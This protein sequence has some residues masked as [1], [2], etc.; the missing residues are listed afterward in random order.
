MNIIGGGMNIG[1][2]LLQIHWSGGGRKFKGCVSKF[3]GCVSNKDT[4]YN[5]WFSLN[6]NFDASPAVFLR[7]YKVL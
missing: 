6:T 5:T 1:L 2:G 4:I 3:K 7:P